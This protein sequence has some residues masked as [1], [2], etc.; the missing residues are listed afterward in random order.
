VNPFDDDPRFAPLDEA[1]AVKRWDPLTLIAAQLESRFAPLGPWVK[2]GACVGS[3][4]TLW[5]APPTTDELHDMTPAH[6]PT[7]R[8]SAQRQRQAASV[9]ASCPVRAECLIDA[10]ANESTVG[11]IRGGVL[12]AQTLNRPR[13]EHDLIGLAAAGHLNASPAGR[14][15]TAVLPAA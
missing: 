5:D 4:P 8:E 13:T 10:Q 15:R 7:P 2:D 11:V 9:C 3:D 12:F 14:G 6:R 1:P